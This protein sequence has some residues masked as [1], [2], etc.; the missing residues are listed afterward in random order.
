MRTRDTSFSTHEGRHTSRKVCSFSFCS[1]SYSYVGFIT[2][3]GAGLKKSLVVELIVRRQR[4][5][6]TVVG[7]EGDWF[8]C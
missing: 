1:S 7:F 6:K 2:V 3:P 8:G 4:S 5:G